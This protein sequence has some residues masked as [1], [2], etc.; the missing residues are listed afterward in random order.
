MLPESVY[1]Y[2]DVWQ[3]TQTPS[4]WLR[5]PIKEASAWFDAHGPVDIYMSTGCYNSKAEGAG[6]FFFPT[7]D[8]DS[9]TL[10]EALDEAKRVYDHFR[11][12]GVKQEDIRSNFSGSQGFHLRISPF[13]FEENHTHK[14][15]PEFFKSYCKWL[16][17]E[18]ELKTLDLSL[19]SKRRLF[20]S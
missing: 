17:K 2:V 11:G 5:I 6:Y 20:R 16:K 1:S 3:R 19:Y 10:S 12:L 4:K 8:F 18:L 13:A 14:K 9:E 7:I 15:F